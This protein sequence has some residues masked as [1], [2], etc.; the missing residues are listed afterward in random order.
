MKLNELKEL[1]GEIEKL[2]KQNTKDAKKVNDNNR[3]VAE[4]Y[5]KGSKEVNKYVRSLKDQIEQSKNVI[6][7]KKKENSEISGLNEV[8]DMF[9]GT[10]DKNV[11][12]MK[13]NI[14]RTI[15]AT[16]NMQELAKQGKLTDDQMKYYNE[17]MEYLNQEIGIMTEGMSQAGEINNLWGIEMDESTK[18]LYTQIEALKK[19]DQQIKNTFRNGKNEIGDFGTAFGKI[20]NLVATPQIKMKANV[21]DIKT[22]LSKLSNIAVLN[23]GNVITNALSK[24]RSVGLARGGIVN[25]PGKGVPI[26]S[27]LTGEATNGAEGV[28]PMNNDEVMDMLGQKIARHIQINLTNNTLLDSRVIAR[29]QTKI[30]SDMNFLTNG[31]G[32]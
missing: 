24:M 27:V 18:S 21:D 20:S 19:D 31:R 11:T 8:W 23:V 13:E 28:I 7:A 3:K 14:Q 1:N 22:T 25:N 29:E 6:D 17:T 9:G 2:N 10:Q 26:G 30:A 5:E 32:V 12:I 15:D 4:S 16:K